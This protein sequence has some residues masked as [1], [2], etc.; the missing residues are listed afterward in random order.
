M[1][2]RWDSPWG[3]DTGKTL[4]MHKSWEQDKVLDQE[5]KRKSWMTGMERHS[6]QKSLALLRIRVDS[7]DGC[8]SVVA[9][10]CVVKLGKVDRRTQKE[11]LTKIFQMSSDGPHT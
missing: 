6:S 7:K 1:E 11:L 5:E 2:P 3:R 10:P 8:D 9:L 4:G